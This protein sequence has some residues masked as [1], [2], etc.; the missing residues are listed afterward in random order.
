MIGKRI[1]DLLNIKYPIIQGGMA[2]IA[3]ST[4]AASVSNAGGLGLI[5]AGN[6]PSDLIR[7]EIKKVKEM[8]DKPFGVNIMLMSPFAHEI[9]QIV[10]E[11][12]V[13]V[14]TT[15]AG[16]PS[17]YIQ[18]WKDYGIK[19]LPVVPSVA[20]AK[21]MENNGA[22]AIIAE[23]CEAGG[24]IG[25]LTTMALIPQIADQIEVPLVAAGGIADGRGVAAAFMLG[26]QGVQVGTRF[27]VANEC[28]AH[29]NYKERII[30]A[31]D[32]DSQVTGRFI[33]LPVRSLKNKLTKNMKEWEKEKLSKEE[34][35]ERG[36]G[37]LRKA[38]KDGDI[39]EGSVMAGQIAGLIKKQQSCREIIEEM[40]SQ[41]EQT[42][43]SF[44]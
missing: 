30:S 10:C 34:F 44:I 24:H 15:G 42:I 43:T 2:W 25:E 36:I 1:C 32:T 11:E 41:A 8:T 19:V 27:I 12:D 21:R 20:L 17:K 18:K 29:K 40:I 37:A 5:A 6:A 9:A 31:K 4:L 14:V 28:T 7:N 33:G 3:D 22:D 13:K 26:A 23:G 16:N 39:N 38:V 35:E